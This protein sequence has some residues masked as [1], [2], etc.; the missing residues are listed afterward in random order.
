[1]AADPD[2][3]SPDAANPD[4]TRPSAAAWEF[5]EP[6]FEA[7][8]LR[9]FMRDG[10][11]KVIPARERKKLVICRH[12]LDRVLPDPDELVQERDLNMRLALIHQDVATIRRAFVDLGFA[13]REG[14]VYRR[15]VPLRS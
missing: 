1:M 2:A 13:T 15:A 4:R 9:A 10:R 3:S 6:R 14:M 8:V 5:D 11:L 7:A 12:L